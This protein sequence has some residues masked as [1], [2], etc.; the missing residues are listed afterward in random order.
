[1][2]FNDDYDESS[3]QK[4]RKFR[5]ATRVD[6]DQA[7]D[8]ER[9]MAAMRVRSMCNQHQCTE[10]ST[11]FC[12]DPNH[13]KDADYLLSTDGKHPGMLDMLGLD[14]AYPAYTDKE[15]ATWLR[16]LGQAGPPEEQAA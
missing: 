6:P 3:E 8:I 16:W 12:D 14:T 15:K 13:R 9:R 5:H 2:E 4:P 10:P 1:M 7:A 11:G